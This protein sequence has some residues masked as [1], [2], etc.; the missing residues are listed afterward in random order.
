M[1]SVNR[2]NIMTNKSTILQLIQQSADKQSNHPIFDYVQNGTKLP[3]E[4]RFDQLQ[5]FIIFSFTF[6]D[7]MKL[8]AKHYE[9]NTDDLSLAIVDIS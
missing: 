1:Y 3:L 2:G 6:S 9:G 8:I 5:K 4:Y 7:I